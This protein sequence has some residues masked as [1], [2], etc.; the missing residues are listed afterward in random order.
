MNA[1]RLFQTLTTRQSYTI[2][3]AQYDIILHKQINKHTQNW[4]I[5]LP[6]DF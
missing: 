1:G 4:F 5:Y 3:F 6:I 2:N